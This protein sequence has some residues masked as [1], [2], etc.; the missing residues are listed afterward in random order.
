MSFVLDNH[1]SSTTTISSKIFR[2]WYYLIFSL[3]LKD[4]IPTLRWNPVGITVAGVSNQPG[5]AS[6]KLNIPIGIVVDYSNSLY[7]ADFGNNRTQKYQRGAT[8][9]QTV[10]GQANGTASSSS[11]CISN[12]ADV[13]IDTN[14][15]VYVLDTSN[16]R[17]QL[18]SDG[19]LSGVTL[20]GTGK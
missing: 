18:W 13:T 17:V 19:S 8:F 6:N 1:T 14:N 20:A 5:T 11:A 4:I 16:H 7:I 15:N 12:P 10:S 3:T 2:L 9:G